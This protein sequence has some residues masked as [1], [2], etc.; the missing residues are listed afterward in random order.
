MDNHDRL[1]KYS[2][3]WRLALGV[4]LIACSSEGFAQS[5]PVVVTRQQEMKAIAAAAKSI[6]GMFKSPETYSSQLFSDAAATIRE[7]SGPRLIDHFSS[8]IIADGSKATEA[9]ATD[10]EKFAKLALDLKRYADILGKAAQQNP[11]E[12]SEDMRMKGGEQMEGGPLGSRRKTGMSST[13]MSAE[14][15]FHMMLQT[16]TSCH[17]TFR[18]K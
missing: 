14:H 3:K 8:V 1:T 17:T 13:E 7:R 12:I 2:A 4:F 16:C 6:A 9:I 18:S 15:A 5:D 10:H 11:D